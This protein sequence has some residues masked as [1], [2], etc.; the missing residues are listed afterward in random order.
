MDGFLKSLG[1]TAE[2]EKDTALKSLELLRQVSV[3][4]LAAIRTIFMRISSGT[5][6]TRS[7]S[8]R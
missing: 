8:S 1:L 2:L 5:I 3:V 6:F 4:V 7:S